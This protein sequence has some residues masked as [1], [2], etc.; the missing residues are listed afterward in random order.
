MTNEFTEP[1]IKIHNPMMNGGWMMIGWW[2]DSGLM[3]VEWILIRDDQRWLGIS[4]MKKR[5]S[6]TSYGFVWLWVD[7]FTSSVD[8]EEAELLGGWKPGTDQSQSCREVVTLPQ[9]LFPLT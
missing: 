9:N 7:F 8:S 6:G 2:V 1:L 4:D 3:R 5:F